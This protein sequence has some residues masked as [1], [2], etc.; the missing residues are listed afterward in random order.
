[1]TDLLSSMQSNQ[2]MQ[3]SDPFS[4]SP[5]PGAAPPIPQLDFAPAPPP[6]TGMSR[7]PVIPTPP[8]DPRQAQLD[9]NVQSDRARMDALEP[10]IED[11]YNRAADASTAHGQELTAREPQIDQAFAMHPQDNIKFVMKQSPIFLGLA[12]LAGSAFHTGALTSLS[13][14][15]GA[16]QG[17]VKGDRQAYDDAMAQ[18][19]E[20]LHAMLLKFQMRDAAYEAGM[21]SYGFSA[22]GLQAAMRHANALIG[23]DQHESD[24]LQKDY[25]TTRQL[26]FTA[27]ENEANRQNA[28]QVAGTRA[29]M[30]AGNLSPEEFDALQRAIDEKRLN[31]DKVNSRTGRIYAQMELRSPGTDYNASAQTGALMRNAQT[32]NRQL[33]LEQLPQIM[34]NVVAAGKQVN[35]S[36]NAWV[37][38]MEKWAKGVSNDP[39]LAEYMAQRNDALMAIANAMRGFGMS[40]G[41]VALENQAFNPTYSPRA[42]EG[43]LKGQMASLGPKLKQAQTFTRSNS[44]VSDMSGDYGGGGAGGDQGGGGGD[45]TIDFGSM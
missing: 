35:Y 15:N 3:A 5:S 13:A 14:M 31:P 1:M 36:D 21:K 18:Y 42:L 16:V 41:A 9:E 27:K 19:Q 7:A 43:W 26:M 44:Y 8:I 45:K 39:K 6:P 17:M 34:S 23:I 32:V 30:G 29:Q 33:T 12:A 4:G 10:K 40:E 24:Q 22:E 37:G 38:V 25:D 20:Q 2:L 28:L 11:V